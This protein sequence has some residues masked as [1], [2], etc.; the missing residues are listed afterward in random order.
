MVTIK[1]G[2]TTSINQRTLSASYWSVGHS[3]ISFDVDACLRPIQP[4]GAEVTS[5]PAP[6]PFHSSA[7]QIIGLL[8]PRSLMPPC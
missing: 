1:E 8:V 2:M 7:H 5:A 3:I 6:L 4:Y